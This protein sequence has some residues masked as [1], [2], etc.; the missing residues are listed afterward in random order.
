MTGLSTSIVLFLSAFGAAIAIEVAVT[1]LRMRQTGWTESATLKVFDM[2][3]SVGF[4]TLAAILGVALSQSALSLPVTCV[5]G[6]AALMPLVFG[7]RYL[8]C[9]LD[10]RRQATAGLDKSS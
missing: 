10:A 8:F 4:M 7:T 5:V 3:L 2:A 9:R 1:A 6:L